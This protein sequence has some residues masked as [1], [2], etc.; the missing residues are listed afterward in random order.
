MIFLLNENKIKYL[1]D[2]EDVSVVTE[3]MSKINDNSCIEL[4]CDGELSTQLFKDASI[5]YLNP[6]EDMVLKN[7]VKDDDCIA[8]VLSSGDFVLLFWQMFVAMNIALA[9]FNMIPL[10]PLDGDRSEKIFWKK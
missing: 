10:P 5:M 8:T 9:V 2:Y 3:H 6:T 1:N 4:D 7:F